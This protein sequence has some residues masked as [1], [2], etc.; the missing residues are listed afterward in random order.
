[1]EDISADTDA[2]IDESGEFKPLTPAN[3]DY[4]EAIVILEQSKGSP[5]IRSVDIATLLNV[6]K[7][8]VNKALSALRDAGYIEQERY[9]RA[10]LTP[11]G[12]AYG[13]EVWGRHQTLRRF[14]IDDLGVEPN[15]ANEE[16]CR[17][18]HS[19]TQ[20]TIEK[21]KAFLVREHGE[22]PESETN[23]AA[24]VDAGVTVKFDK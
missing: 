13:T 24:A 9:G 19:V 12:R 11:S 6:S 15:L 7:A 1:M 10:T 22:Q 17:M 5:A 20:G 23:I 16:A 14:L 2:T 3:E 18:E 21:L 4:L 8:S